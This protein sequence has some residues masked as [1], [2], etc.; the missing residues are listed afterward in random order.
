MAGVNL[1]SLTSFYP[2]ETLDKGE[3]KIRAGVR[4]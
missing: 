2:N 4:S 1:Q 3:R